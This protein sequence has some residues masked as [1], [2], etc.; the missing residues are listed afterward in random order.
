LAPAILLVE[1]EG[2]VAAV[3]G[4]ELAQREAALLTP[5]PFETILLAA[6]VP[7]DQAHPH[8]VVRCRERR[9]DVAPR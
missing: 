5:R 4:A 9:Q 6:G 8:A 2:V 3:F 1:G 7:A